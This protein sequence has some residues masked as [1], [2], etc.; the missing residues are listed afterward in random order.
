MSAEIEHLT[1]RFNA[2][3]DRY[4]Q[5]QIEAERSSDNGGRGPTP[6]DLAEARLDAQVLRS[7]VLRARDAV[8]RPTVDAIGRV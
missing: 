7:R 2:A 4:R 3:L 1:A 5:L 6:A 8:S